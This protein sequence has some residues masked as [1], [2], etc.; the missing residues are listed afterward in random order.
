MLGTLLITGGFSAFVGYTIVLNV[1]GGKAERALS[2]ARGAQSAT[3][4]AEMF[5]TDAERVVAR[6]LYPRLEKLTYTKAFPL[7]KEDRLFSTP[8]T[9]SIL[10]DEATAYYLNFDDEDV[11]D[12]AIAVLRDLSCDAPK[13]VIADEMQGVETIGQLVTGLAKLTSRPATR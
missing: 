9:G 1:R 4:F 12:D 3:T 7:S 10:S 13:S 6:M 2:H 5:P 11:W 8:H